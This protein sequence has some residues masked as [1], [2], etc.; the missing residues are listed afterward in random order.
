ML[1]FV[2]YISKND[3]I[4][5]FHHLKFSDNLGG[6]GLNQIS[7]EGVLRNLESVKGHRKIYGEY[8]G[9]CRNV[10][11]IYSSLHP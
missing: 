4:T 3:M 8:N 7:L 1:N 6:G 2:R 11:G 10:Y 5:S 9:G